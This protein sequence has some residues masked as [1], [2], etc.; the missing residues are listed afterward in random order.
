MNSEGFILENKGMSS[1]RIPKHFS[2]ATVAAITVAQFFLILS[3]SAGNLTLNMN[4]NGDAI[5]VYLVNSSIDDVEIYPLVRTY[6]RD[7]EINFLFY[8][9][10]GK[11]SECTYRESLTS[12]LA[13]PPQK[14]SFTLLPGQV[15]G[16]RVKVAS[17]KKAYGLSDGC[18][19]VFAEYMYVNE[20]S[21]NRIFSGKLISN[22]ATVCM[23]N[24]KRR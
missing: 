4:L 13:M 11:C 22:V 15:F 20:S 23:R 2:R 21:A 6:G 14:R 19:G 5:D 7:R 18:Y 24:Q 8:R 3:A 12:P 10:E 1:P 9:K 17:L 16:T